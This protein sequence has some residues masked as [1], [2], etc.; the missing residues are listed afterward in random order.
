MCNTPLP[1]GRPR[2]SASR[3]AVLRAAYEML[4]ERGYGLLAIEAVAARAGVGK[5]TIYRWWPNRAVLAVEAFFE[6]TREDL[7]F[8]DTGSAREDF[9]LQIAQLANLL[10]GAAGQA[11]AGLVEGARTDSEIG[12]AVFEHWVLP[13]KRWGL[14]RLERA[15]NEGQSRPDLDR[16]AALQALYSPLY[17]ALLL[18]Q[19]VPAPERVEACFAVVADGVFLESRR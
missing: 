16:E 19:G 13:R 14:E 5:A 1:R 15:Q 17:A 7:A 2:S 10:R 9:R 12:R 3:E 11:F 18:G 6:A 8:P 4:V